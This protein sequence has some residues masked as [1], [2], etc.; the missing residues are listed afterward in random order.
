MVHWAV[1]ITVP[2]GQFKPMTG[3]MKWP[4][5]IT[6]NP[7]QV[8]CKRCKALPSFREEWRAR[9][10]GAERNLKLQ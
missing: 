3:C 7:E 1:W 9:V 4:G 8:T 2:G 10:R 5:Q 6:E